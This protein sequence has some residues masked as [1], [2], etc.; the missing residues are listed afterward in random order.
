MKQSKHN[1]HTLIEQLGKIQSSADTVTRNYGIDIS[2]KTPEIHLLD[3]IAEEPGI[4]FT[5]LAERMGSSKMV[6]SNRVHKLEEKG[7]L[8][9]IHGKNKK[10]LSCELTPRG[11]IAVNTHSAYHD[12][13]NIYLSEKLSKY[14]EEDLELVENFLK[15]YR[16][17]LEMY[18]KDATIL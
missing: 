10:E 14:S 18:A 9:I 15:D 12:M 17:Y 8:R 7:L 5:L 16:T 2:L 4:N 3:T 13:E 1:F 6:I 11:Q